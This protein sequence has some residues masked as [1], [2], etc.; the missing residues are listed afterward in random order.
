MTLAKLWGRTYAFIGL[1]RIGGV[2]VYD[3]TD[4]YAPSFVQYLNNRDFGVKPGTPEAGD[5]GAEGLTVIEASKSPIR[6][7]PLLVVANEVS[8]TT[9][10]FR[11]ERIRG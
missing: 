9:T 8:G 1:E 4:P 7:V 2:M 10:L 6:G 3:V 5:L 11:I